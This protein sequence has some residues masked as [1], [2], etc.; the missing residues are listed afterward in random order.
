[1]SFKVK[2]VAREKYPANVD[3]VLGAGLLY[4][5]GSVDLLN[6]PAIGICGSRNA[7]PNA[8]RYAYEFG[9]EA[10]RQGVIVVS[11]YARGVDRQAHAGALEAGGATIAVLPEGIDGFRVVSDM[12]DLIQ[13]QENFLALSMFEPSAPWT[14]W[15][16]MARNKLIVAL[17][18]ALFVVEAGERGGTINAAYES[19]RQGKRVYAIAYE[20][21]LPGREG[22]RK[23]LAASA[24]PLRH[25][26]DLRNALEEAMSHPPAEVRQLVL[27]LTGQRDE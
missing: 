1:M 15:R 12:R 4:A 5:I 17:S 16:A 20:R 22:N 6:R 14:V 18:A 9:E 3:D 25:K 13:P 26:R 8:L 24:I 23:L 27:T 19:V 7:S 21:D 2:Q 11:G 10:A